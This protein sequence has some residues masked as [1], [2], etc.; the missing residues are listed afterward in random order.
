ECLERSQWT[1]RHR[2]GAGL[3]ARRQPAAHG[4]KSLGRIGRTLGGR[5]RNGENG[6]R[7][8][9]IEIIVK[10]GWEVAHPNDAL[11]AQSTGTFDG[12][13]EL[14]HVARPM[15]GD[16]NLHGLSGDLES[17]ARLGMDLVAQ[18]MADQKG[19]VIRT[20]AEGGEMDG[21]HIE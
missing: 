9:L 13:F 2:L 5:G 3:S 11:L 12:V 16:Q 21:N 20:L 15:M 8:V 18:E 10:G 14:A 7:G 6:V 1:I 19:N 4:V 17:L